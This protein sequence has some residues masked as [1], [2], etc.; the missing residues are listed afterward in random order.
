MRTGARVTTALWLMVTT[1]PSRTPQ[2]RGV[3]RR[4]SAGC[5]PKPPWSVASDILAA[6]HCWRKRRPRP[7]HPVRNTRRMPSGAAAG[8]TSGRGGVLTAT[9]FALRVGDNA[10]M[11]HLPPPR[12][13]VA[14]G[15]LRL[16][17]L[18]HEIVSRRRAG[19]GEQRQY[20]MRVAA[21]IERTDQRLND[22][23]GA[24]E[25]AQIGPALERMRQRQMPT[26]KRRRLVVVARRDARRRR[27]VSSAFANIEAA[28]GV[29]SRIGVEDEQASRRGRRAIRL[30][31]PS[32]SRH[33]FPDAGRPARSDR[34]VPAIAR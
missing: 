7:R 18:A 12:L 34:R 5:C 33:D 2:T 28:G 20:I 31:A 13:E 16:P 8:A 15:R 11:Q 14:A 19:A 10:V 4:Q 27:R 23:R 17:S 9:G 1:S 6:K 22:A 21:V 32:M 30:R 25:G 29:I 26:A 3:A 24:V